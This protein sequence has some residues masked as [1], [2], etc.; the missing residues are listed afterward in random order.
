MQ[1]NI[2]DLI[3]AASPSKLIEETEVTVNGVTRVIFV[4]KFTFIEAD[5][6]RVAAFGSDGKFS[7]ANF[8]GN[9][10]RFVASGLVDESGMPV[11]GYDEICCWPP[12]L[13]DALSAAV[14][15][16]N[17]LAP[18]QEAVVGNSSATSGAVSSSTSP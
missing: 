10:A 16:V 17:K 6:L 1:Q 14:D 9:N 12:E 2:Q 3:A 4:K 11:A 18:K 8:A 7:A 15:K 5:R 13:V